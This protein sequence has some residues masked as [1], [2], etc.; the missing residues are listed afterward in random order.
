MTSYSVGDTAAHMWNGLLSVVIT[1]PS[2]CLQT[3]AADTLAIHLMSSTCVT[4]LILLSVLICEV[5]SKFSWLYGTL[6][7]LL[8][9]YYN[10]FTA[11]WTL[12]GTI[13]VSWYQ[14]KHSP[15]HLSWSFSHPLTPIVVINHPLSAFS[16]YHNPRHPPVQST[17]LTVTDVTKFAF[18][19]DNM[20]TS[21]V[22]STF[23]IRRM[24]Y[25]TLRRMRIYG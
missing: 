25:R 19:Y 8:H 11:L 15:T 13:Q 23:D 5:L 7:I 24:F 2:L 17:Y 1:L 22:F 21:N 18:A 3:T 10:R 16:I 20:W 9:Y 14:K 4:L 6:I 12:F